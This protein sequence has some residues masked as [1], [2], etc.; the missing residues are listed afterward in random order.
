MQLIRE[1][2][3][4][5]DAVATLRQEG[6]SVAL[7]PTMGA[8]HAGHM[9]L[10][11]E[12]KRHAAHV[13]VSI[14]VN[15]TQFG[16]NEDLAA[17]PRR[18][19]SDS[20]MLEEAG[21]ALLWAPGVEVMYP[22]GYATTVSV[23]G[24]SEGLCGASRPGH[25][26]GVA[27][28]VAKLFNQVR[29]DVALFGEKDYQQL[30]VIR[31]MTRDLDLPVEVI[32]V[33][34]QR[35]ADGLALSSRNIYLSH[36][37]RVAARALP[38]ALGEAARAIQEGVGIDEALATAR[39]KLAAAGFDPIDYVELCD[40]ETLQPL[41]SLSRPGRLLAAARLGRTRLIDNLPVVPEDH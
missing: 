24:V 12:A 23:A 26:D 22:E 5:R 40:A 19:A 3:A 27:T 6:G 10:V 13:I 18:E 33:P 34:T 9:A 2:D 28:V 1:I 38:R 32:G 7:V 25:F 20:R 14:F 36:E 30:A 39:G 11:A 15:P 4:L 16:P 8:L 21:C 41:S 17:Y 35:D 29:P 37:E 31:R